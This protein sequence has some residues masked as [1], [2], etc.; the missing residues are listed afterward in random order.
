MTTTAQV[1]RKAFTVNT[2]GFGENHNAALLQSISQKGNGLYF[3]IENA[4]MVA[5]AFLDCVGGLLSV[6]GQNLQLVVQAEEGVE[7]M[8]IL[9][10]FPTQRSG[11]NTISVAIPDIQSTES[12]DLL[13][14]C[15]L[16]ALPAP[17]TQQLVLRAQLTYH[18]CISTC[19][20]EVNATAVVGRPSDASG[21][22]INLDIDVNRN[23]IVAAQALERSTVL[24]NSGNLV[25]AREN[26]TTAM[27]H[28]RA[29]LTS[30]HTMTKGLISALEA[31]LKLL[32]DQRSWEHTGSKVCTG[33][34]DGYHQQR[35]T[36]MMSEMAN[37]DYANLKQKKMKSSWAKH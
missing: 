27:T 21:A 15:R 10:S 29:S 8:Q 11:A 35:S 20:D 18:N 19:D 32:V 16:S 28:L 34:S 4:E 2:F 14:V 9:T 33:L 12:R 6:V 3:Y 23:R 22:V 13:C 31:A 30:E 36:P 7:L 37:V 1:V 5:N 24:G 26:L 17:A 25:Q